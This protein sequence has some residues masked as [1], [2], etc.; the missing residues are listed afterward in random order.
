MYL[1]SGSLPM[2]AVRAAYPAV[3]R[4]G[5]GGSEMHGGR[6]C[7]IFRINLRKWARGFLDRMSS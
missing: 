5:S 1:F 6:G 4:S 7:E 2:L 3:Y